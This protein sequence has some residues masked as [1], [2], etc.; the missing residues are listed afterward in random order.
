MLELINV[1]KTYTT[2][3]GN[4]VALNG[5]NIVFP[6]KGM[7]FITGKSGSGKTTL[8]NVVGG[9]D[10]ID[11]GEIIIDGRKF[12]SFSQA[13]YN[14][15][16]NTFVGFVFQ[17]Y[18]LLSEYS[19]EKNI[20]MA[21]ELQ[22]NVTNEETLNALLERVGIEGYAK[23]NPTEMSGG[24]KQRV[25]IARALIKNPKIILADEPTGA[26]DSASGKQVMDLLKELSKEKL[27]VVVSH[28]ME[29]AEK[30][31][32]R[33]I[34][35]V[36]GVIVEDLLVSEQ[37][38]KGNVYEQESEITVVSGST[39]TEE[40][41]KKLAFAVK[42]RKKIIV[43]E[44]LNVREKKKTGKIEAVH[45]ET[46]AKLI[47]S[48]MKFSTS[49]SLGMKSLFVKPL[50][51][52][53]TIL[54]SVVAFALF[55]LFDSV[56][57][58]NGVSALAH[59]LRNNSY[60][61]VSVYASYKNDYYNNA[62]L[63]IS[64]EYINSVSA[65]TGYAFKGVYDIN[66]ITSISKSDAFYGNYNFN[67]GWTLEATE[68]YNNTIGKDYYHQ[69]VTGLIEFN[70][71]ELVKR[72]GNETF[73]STSSYNYRVYGEYPTL[74]NDDIMPEV[75]ISNYM[76]E[77][78]IYWLGIKN[79]QLTTPIHDGK[80][81]NS[82]EDLIGTTIKISN[83]STNDGLNNQ[84]K[85]SG[86]VDCG[87]LPAKYD[88]LKSVMSGIEYALEQDFNTYINASLNKLLFVA[89]G[90]VEQIR[91]KNKS[92]THYLA[93]YV[94]G[95]IEVGAGKDIKD[96]SYVF[97]NVKDFTESNTIMFNGSTGKPTLKSNEVLVSAKVLAR[98]FVEEKSSIMA[99]VEDRILLEDL[100]KEIANDTLSLARRREAVNELV[101]LIKKIHVEHKDNFKEIQTIFY[102]NGKEV[103][104]ETLVVKGIYFDVDINVRQ[105]GS[106]YGILALSDDGFDFLNI[107][108]EQGIYSRMIAP[109]GFN[110]FGA[111][112]LANAMS[113]ETGVKLNWYENN[114]LSAI[115]YN[116]EYIE[117]FSNLFLYV[118][119]VVVV[120]SVFL[121]FNYVATSIISKKQSI[122][123]L[124]GLGASSKNIFLMFMVESVIISLIS[125]ILATIFSYV[126]CIIVSGYIMNIMNL[127]ISF[128]LFGL[129]QILIIIF[130]S[131]LTGFLASLIPIIKITK[132]KP[133]D[134]IRKI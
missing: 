28:E 109:L 25:A 29:F 108:K 80:E 86:I 8:L 37:Q 121:L 13:D 68:H 33:I 26:L 82:I 128:V 127:A 99:N 72:N 17:E 27:V 113:M 12:S 61:A 67:A 49:A 75:A 131:L 9:L 122:G 15:Y 114:V 3:A 85:I 23:R 90:Y 105:S 66:D 101:Q 111:Q 69:Q 91:T 134:L 126:A 46:P 57:S 53:F 104:N 43:K 31:A 14:S 36:D 40:E 129:R 93:N 130:A 39:L 65:S 120:F 132:E 96:Y 20:G 54:L 6:D 48:K 87:K 117:D 52:I 59:L 50:R 133:V 83:I 10:N 58:Y 42:E 112:T 78:I 63:K 115:D 74:Q 92:V 118:A 94:T 88:L 77:S 5:I 95:N 107:N 62:K 60:G 116:K 34:R 55:G 119:L 110:Y 125:G 79:P 97:Y 16:R 102:E 7:V 56:A 73:I 1:K 18:N 123:V 106:P 2:K 47:N 38:I 44:E 89:D 35:F 51:L 30:Y 64:Q 4:T 98:L 124:R 32:D 103:I 41:T 24:Q 22:G 71:N 70:E 45:P 81:I 84:F 19:V 76:A 100:T 11:S 21:N